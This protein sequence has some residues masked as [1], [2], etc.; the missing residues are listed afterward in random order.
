MLRKAV[1]AVALPIVAI[2]ACGSDR[3]RTLTTDGQIA[4]GTSPEA[5]MRARDLRRQFKLPASEAVRFEANG[6]RVTTFLAGTET[7]SAPADVVLP[8]RAI[9]R[10]QIVDRKTKMEA[11]FTLRGATDTPLGAGDDLAVYLGG[12]GTADI[13]HRVH[14]EGTEDYVAFETRPA[15][16]ELT[17]DLDVSQAAGL[18]FLAHMNQLELLDASGVPRLR[19]TQ[20]YVIDAGGIRH[21]ATLSVTGCVVDRDPAV[22]W[23]RAVTPPGARSCE[24]H[25]AWRDVTYPA[26][27]DPA[28]STTGMA[29][30][31]RQDHTSTLLNTGDVLITGGTDQTTVWNIAEVYNEASGAFTGAGP[32]ASAR[33]FHTATKLN[34]GWVVLIGGHTTSADTATAELYNPGTNTFGFTGSLTLGTRQQHTATLLNNGTVLVAG[35]Q[36][37]GV[38]TTATGTAEIFSTSSFAAT[39]SMSPRQLH[40][41]TLL[42]NG[43]VLVAGGTT[44]GGDYLATA[45]LFTG[46]S[47]IAT[48][49]LL[50]GRREHTATLLGNGTVVVIGGTNAEKTAEI[51]AGGVW[52]NT[53]SPPQE[54]RLRHHATLLDSGKVLVAHGFISNNFAE[55]FD[56]VTSSFAYTGSTKVARQW[57]KATKL[58]SGRVLVTGGPSATAELYD[59]LAAGKTCVSNDDCRSSACNGDTAVNKTC[60]SAAC[61]APCRTCANTAG[62][63]PSFACAV[64]TNAE[65]ADS[66][67]GPNICSAGGACKLKLGQ[68]C[69]LGSSCASGFCSDGVCCNKAC[70]GGC[71]RCDAT[72][73]CNTVPSGTAGANPSCGGFVCDGINPGC[74]G[75]CTNDADC[76]GGQYC[77]ANGTC[78]AKKA[79]GATCNPALDCKDAACAECATAACVDG[80]C[81]DTTCTGL[82]Q[83]CAAALKQSG[84]DGKCGPAREGTNPH[85]D[86]CPVDAPSTCG[87][88]GKCSGSGGCRAFYPAGTS[89]GASQCT[90]DT[91]KAIGNICNGSGTCVNDTVG[92]SCFDYVCDPA[93]GSCPN[94]CTTDAQCSATAYCNKGSCVPKAN[95]GGACTEEKQC[96]SNLCV[97]GFCCNATCDGQCEACDVTGAEGTCAPLTGVPHQQRPA[98]AAPDPANPCATVTCDGETRTSCA[99]FVGPEVTCGAATCANG[100]ATL[101]G[102]CRKGSC[103][104]ADP[105]PC[106]AYAC[107]ATACNTSCEKKEDCAP[108]NVCDPATKRCISQ[109]TC[110]GDHT[111][112]GANGQKQDCSPFKCQDDGTCRQACRSVDDCVA[113]NACDPGSGK[114]VPPP[115]NDAGD[116]GGCSMT[117]STHSDTSSLGI[118]VGLAFIGALRRRRRGDKLGACS[119]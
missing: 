85:H 6:E 113:P 34:N 48:G 17:Y 78:Q 5:A 11:S 49:S 24:I 33:K 50:K 46:S 63:N 116:S 70:S 110:D 19:V 54:S 1:L 35:G 74:P 20:P 99:G 77:S 45:Q 68:T 108:N 15:R 61:S 27:V 83:A 60:C 9:G 59:L 109:A 53:A 18:R 14:A 2:V 96:A 36:L 25:V 76:A 13:V 10:T 39:G 80:V 42:P 105:V 84:A 82:C 88:D 101:P 94:A 115:A 75:S 28:W 41:A 69:N 7:A 119:A 30:K 40:T 64:I 29:S 91:N 8:A 57:P 114:C 26:M 102:N 111:T 67:T 73:T 98:C 12:Y 87:H 62:A 38:Q 104:T 31:S 93:T 118:V 52:S 95:N 71:D 72:G 56:P 47:F 81:C 89:C 55:L 106:G 4:I 79:G 100:K 44:N 66:C 117:S 92:V 3:D 21:D 23:G 86:T 43:N 107:G 32:M 97:D 90:T 65:D 37:A 16:E 51:Y 103:V 22:P 112:T 58:P